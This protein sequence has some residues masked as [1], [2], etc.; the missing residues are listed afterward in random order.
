MNVSYKDIFF[1]LNYIG[2]NRRISEKK[3]I[4][5]HLRQKHRQAATNIKTQSQEENQSLSFYKKIRNDILIFE[6]N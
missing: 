5:F 4:N 1:C 2:Y 3:D 6:K